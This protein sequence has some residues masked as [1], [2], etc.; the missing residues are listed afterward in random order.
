MPY[1]DRRVSVLTIDIGA[2]HPDLETRSV[3]HNQI[4][5]PNVPIESLFSGNGK[6][7]AKFE[8]GVSAC[9]PSGKLFQDGLREKLL[10]L[11]VPGDRLRHPCAGVLIPIVLPSMSNQNAPH[12][13]YLLYEVSAFHATSNSAT[14]RTA[15]M[16]PPDKS[17]YKSRRCS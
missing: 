2:A 3:P 6:L 11:A 16:C 8:V 4:F 17:A 10:D 9:S 15:G 7:S 5:S 12:F 14:F 13:L 1:L